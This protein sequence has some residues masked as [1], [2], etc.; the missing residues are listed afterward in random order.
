M[1]EMVRH[2]AL[3]EAALRHGADWALALDAD[4]RVERAFRARAER[5]IAR[6]RLL[7][8]TALYVRMRDLWDAHD[9]Y[10]T[11][12]AWG[13]KRHLRLF[14][15]RA[16]HVFDT[17][18][19]H[20]EKGPLEARSRTGDLIV[21]HLGMLTETDRTARRRRYET[22]D[23]DHRWQRI[24]YAHLTDQTGLRLARVPRRR[25]WVE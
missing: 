13:Q 10:R 25:G 20:G 11:D 15:L 19:L 21:Y 16:D 9:R 6:G 17:A 8:L 3:V 22:L 12:G 23:P 4:E 2:R 7:G 1:G 14:A 18:P 24:G 5:V